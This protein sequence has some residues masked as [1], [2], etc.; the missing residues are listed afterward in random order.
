MVGKFNKAGTLLL[1]TSTLI[2]ILAM[3]ARRLL[4]LTDLG[5][6]D[7]FQYFIAMF[8]FIGVGAGF[9]A[10]SL[11]SQEEVSSDN[12][13][14]KLIIVGGLYV[15]VMGF[16]LVVNPRWLDLSISGIGL[17][18]VIVGFLFYFEFHKKY[19]FLHNPSPNMGKILLLAWMV[20]LLAVFLLYWG[21]PVEFWQVLDRFGVNVDTLRRIQKFLTQFFSFS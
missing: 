2:I 16:V 11:V 9:F 13:F 14:P 19:I 4:L 8:G 15:F 3:A 12:A 17:I 6:K 7:W 18:G 10:I 20:L 21:A 1:I 5:P